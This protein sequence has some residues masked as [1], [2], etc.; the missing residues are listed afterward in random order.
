MWDD[1]LETPLKYLIG[2]MPGMNSWYLVLH[3]VCIIH[4]AT[5]HQLLEK[6]SSFHNSLCVHALSALG[7]L[8]TYF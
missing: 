4:N 2:Q 1:F 7:T 3:A 6:I 5:C 8:G